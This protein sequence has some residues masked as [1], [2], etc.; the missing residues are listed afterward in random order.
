MPDPRPCAVCG[1]PIVWHECPNYGIVALDPEPVSDGHYFVVDGVASHVDTLHLKLVE[2]LG[3]PRY[4][5]HV[6][7]CK[8]PEPTRKKA[9]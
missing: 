1:R 7:T 6:R 8:P 2:M 4:Q 5:N 3:G 9:S